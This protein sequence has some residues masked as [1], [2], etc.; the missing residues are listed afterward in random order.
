MDRRHAIKQLAALAGLSAIGG[1]AF[2]QREAFNTLDPVQ[3]TEDQSRIEVLEFFHYGCP[4]CRDFDPLIEAWLV[5]LPKDVYFK[6]VPAIWGNPQL[7]ELARLYYT[8]EATGD[9]HKIHGAVFTAF[10]T[11]KRPINTE[12]GVREW[13][14]TQGVNVDKFMATYKSFGIQSQLSRAEQLAKNFRIQG[15][16]A[17][18]VNG[19]FTT[20]ASLTGSHPNTLKVV[21]QLIA[22]SR[23]ERK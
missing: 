16:P 14:A 12:A 18:A 1:Y 13:I 17:M 22:Q 3:P 11:E 19:R 20:S 23:G 8:A 10:Q 7:R 4:H 6:R 5:T 9:L 21:D 15:V 2:A